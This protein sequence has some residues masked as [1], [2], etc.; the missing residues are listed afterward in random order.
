MRD[1]NVSL[2]FKATLLV[3]LPLVSNAQDEEEPIKE[4]P[5]KE[6]LS[7][8]VLDE[9]I[10]PNTTD[11]EVVTKPGKLKKFAKRA[12]KLGDYYSTVNYLEKFT[13]IKPEKWKY[14]W[15]LAESYRL[16]RD[17]KN[18]EDM[19]NKIVAT[20]AKK[21]PKA[22]FY[23]ATVQK[24]N[25]FYEEAADKWLKEFMK[26]YKGS[27]ASRFKKL[28][29]AEQA[30]AIKAKSIIDSALK[31]VISPLPKSINL[32]A[33]EST[34]IIVD[35]STLIYGSIFADIGE[36]YSLAGEDRPERKLMLAK[37]TSP[38]EWKPA[39]ELP[40]PFN[41]LGYNVA[42]G[43]YSIDRLRFYF[44]RCPKRITKK[45]NCAIWMSQFRDGEWQEPSMLNEVVNQKE[46]NSTQPAVGSF[47]DKKGKTVDV[48]YFVSD[49]EGGRGGLDLW[50]SLVDS[51]TGDFKKAKNL[52]SK[53]NSAGDDITPFY[54][55][56]AGAL[57]FSS[58]GHPSIGGFDIFRAD[59]THNKLSTPQNA[60]YPL[61]SPA[62]DSFF[63][64]S[65]NQDEGYFV[66]NRAGGNSEANP[67]CCD[68]IY[69]FRYT[70][71]IRIGLGGK[72]FEQ[73][74]PTDQPNPANLLDGVSAYLM[75]ID[76]EDPTDTIV[77]KS[78]ESTTKDG[79]LFTLQYNNNYILK[80]ERPDYDTRYIQFA[81]NKITYSDTIFENVGLKK[82][83]PKE[84]YL[85]MVFFDTNKS[86]ITKEQKD[87][88]RETV[89]KFVKENPTVKLRINGHTDDIGNDRFNVTLSAKRAE[90]VYKFLL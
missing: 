85:P 84:V 59:G 21:Y 57:Y 14:N 88:M 42:S 69:N 41:A 25:G 15:M 24:S 66:S 71:F 86:L 50:Y 10:D 45:N 26:E 20:K 51:K 37:K 5:N 62:D 77:L 81:T 79:Y 19:Y 49:R 2:F 75:K 32:P 68:D 78:I 36:Y 82:T 83:P 8:Q 58:N 72:L 40:G 55:Q 38:I 1:F 61:N 29:K 56:E 27:D 4:K 90:A 35:E 43:A 7:R 23:L 31:V 70:D 52:G 16:T 17:Y 80:F 22:K 12:Y 73:I 47:Q 3:L 53:V 39:G 76:P 13:A 87:E 30:G 63:V 89:V 74:N 67:T 48:L 64:L 34:P 46:F 33:M 44:T 54:D 28:S 65:K 11:P 60:G 9:N 18:A 6:T